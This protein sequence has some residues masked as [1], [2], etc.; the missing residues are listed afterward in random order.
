[1]YQTEFESARQ[2]AS[3]AGT[4]TADAESRPIAAA[5]SM[6]HVG[7]SKVELEMA[8]KKV[9]DRIERRG[10]IFLDSEQDF[11]DTNNLC[12]ALSAAAAERF[13]ECGIADPASY[14]K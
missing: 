6:Q 13:K 14:F 9:K 8:V 7:K 3:A 11:H 10:V 12:V 5:E 4:L 1:M 2:A